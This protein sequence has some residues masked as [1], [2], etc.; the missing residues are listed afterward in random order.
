MNQTKTFTVP[1]P[2][3]MCPRCVAHVKEALEAVQGVQNVTV[4]LE[5]KNAVVLAD[6]TADME[7]KL[8]AAV[9]AAGYDK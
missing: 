6:D 7:K 1:A 5:N 9:H 4:S 8:F 2:G 3:M